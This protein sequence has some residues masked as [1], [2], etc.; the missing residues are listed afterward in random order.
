M[1]N[2]K[3]TG[4]SYSDSID[5][6]L[7][8]EIEKQQKSQSTASKDCNILHELFKPC[9]ASSH[10]T[11]NRFPHI[12]QITY[13]QR[14]KKVTIHKWEYPDVVPYTEQVDDAPRLPRI[15]I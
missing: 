15:Q 11:D 2:N 5:Y 7:I 13:E 8:K 4:I 10:I 1:K 3:I 9:R 14:I 12:A 6:A